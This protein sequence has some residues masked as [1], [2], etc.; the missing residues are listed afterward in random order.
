MDFNQIIF[1]KAENQIYNIHV[2]NIFYNF[3]C[4]I[5]SILL[6]PQLRIKVIFPK[7]QSQGS[8]TTKQDPFDKCLSNL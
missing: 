4:S 7:L 8:C 3:I 5:L 2:F 6:S 1:H